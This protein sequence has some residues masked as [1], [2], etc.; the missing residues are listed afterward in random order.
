MGEKCPFH[1]K[2][3]KS[4]RTISEVTTLQ[5]QYC[6]NNTEHD[7]THLSSFLKF[8]IYLR[9]S[10]STVMPGSYPSIIKSWKINHSPQHWKQLL[11]IS[12]HVLS[13][14]TTLTRSVEAGLAVHTRGTKQTQTPYSRFPL[15]SLYIWYLVIFSRR[16][17]RL[18]HLTQK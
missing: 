13:A 1:K 3:W 12:L 15:W 6:L 8:K 7:G 17:L 18:L 16:V 4:H 10:Q 11:E 14:H 9:V 2:Q 5:W